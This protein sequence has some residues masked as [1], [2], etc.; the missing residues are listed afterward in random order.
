[1]RLYGS[2]DTRGNPSEALPAL[3]QKL[4]EFMASEEFSETSETGKISSLL[5]LAEW[6]IQ[7][8]CGKKAIETDFPAGITIHGRFSRI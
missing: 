8:V 5:A 2:H 1:V 4:E 3:S 7:R 6:S